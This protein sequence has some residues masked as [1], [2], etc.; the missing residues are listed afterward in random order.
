MLCMLDSAP[1]ELA[2]EDHSQ[3]CQL[4]SQIQRAMC[5]V[6]TACCASQAELRQYGPQNEY[7]RN[8][9]P[10]KTTRDKAKY[11]IRTLHR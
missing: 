3:Q 7:Q 11:G 8:H 10:L 5:I 1:S 6:Q 2:S 9:S 4:P